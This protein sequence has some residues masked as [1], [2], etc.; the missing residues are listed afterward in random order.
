M[1]KQA[2]AVNTHNDKHAGTGGKGKGKSGGKGVTK[3]V[4][5]KKPP[6]KDVTPSSSG[7]RSEEH[8]GRDSEIPKGNTMETFFQPKPVST[9]TES[10]NPVT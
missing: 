2:Y 7:K 3:G 10:Q 8:P 5:K 9:A 6:K 4:E 1:A